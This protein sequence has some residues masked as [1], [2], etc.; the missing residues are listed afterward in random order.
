M[1]HLIN[2][3]EGLLCETVDFH[4]ATLSVTDDGGKHIGYPPDSIV[5]KSEDCWVCDGSGKDIQ[6]DAYKARF[7]KD[8]PCE[9]CEGLGKHDEIDY[10]FPNLNVANSNAFHIADMLGL[11]PDY[12]GW[13]PLEEIPNVLRRLIRLKNGEVADWTKSLSDERGET[14][15]DY[16]GAVPRIQGGA[17]MIG[18]EITFAQVERYIDRLMDICK[19]AQ[20][21][22]CGVSWA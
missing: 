3:V 13:I 21:H 9:R 19:W 5:K 12:T 17:R 1:R 16:T 18:G 10:N 15:V 14:K 7:G 22:G 2:L 8:L 6:N 20:D 4:P 11:E